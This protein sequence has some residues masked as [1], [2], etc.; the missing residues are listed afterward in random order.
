M[1]SAASASGFCRDRDVPFS[2]Y[3]D[4]DRSAYLAFGLTN[5]PPTRWANPRTIVR[6]AGLFRRGIS[7]GLP[8]PG[9]DIR[10]MPGTFVVARGGTVRYAHY[11]ADAS[12]N[13]PIEAL[14]G[15][16]GAS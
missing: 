3:A 12:D 10:Q 16:L 1:G 4:P 11:N 9:Q 14:L 8:H 5:A 7:S 2:C 13:A 15:A 6:G